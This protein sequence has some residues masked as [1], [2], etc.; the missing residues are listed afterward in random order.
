MEP[1][2]VMIEILAPAHPLVFKVQVEVEGGHRLHASAVLLA[3]S[4]LQGALSFCLF[5]TLPA[6]AVTTVAVVTT[7]STSRAPGADS[8]GHH[9]RP[10]VCERS[11]PELSC[12]NPL[13]ALLNPQ[14][15]RS[16]CRQGAA[17]LACRKNQLF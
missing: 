1:A 14:K 6:L 4:G 13:L 7:L 8:R 17:A 16:K 11:S 2:I 15:H 3:P 10:A 12:A 5:S 9:S